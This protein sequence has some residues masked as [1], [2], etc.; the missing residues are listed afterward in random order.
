MTI[1]IATKNMILHEASQLFTNANQY[2]SALIQ[3]IAKKTGASDYV[4]K[5]VLFNRLSLVASPPPVMTKELAMGI[6]EDI[7]KTDNILQHPSEDKDA[8]QH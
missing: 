3:R 1:D 8:S 4:I 6:I 5:K 2:N 7:F